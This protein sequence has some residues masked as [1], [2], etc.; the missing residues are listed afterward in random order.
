[1][2]TRR[3][4]LDPV[5]GIAGDMFVGAMLDAWPDHAEGTVGAI[6]AAGLADWVTLDVRPH[7][8]HALT[9]TRFDVS[10]PK[11]NEHA[12]HTPFKLVRDRLRASDLAAGPRDRAIDIFT[13]LADAEGRVH[14][15]DR[16]DVTFHEVGNWDSV[17]DVVGAAYLIDAVGD[18]GW[19]VGSLPMGSGR[20]KSAHGMLALPAPAVTELLTGFVMH[21]DGREGER[22]TPTGA[23]ILSH[24]EPKQ[25]GPYPPARLMR[26]GTGFGTREFPGIS[27]VLRVLEFEAVGLAV[28][29]DEV[30]VVRFEIDDQTP[31]DLAVGL[32]RLRAMAGVLDVLQTPAY[33]KK[34]RLVAQIQVLARPDVLDDVLAGC[35]TEST[36]L[37]LRWEIVRRATLERST[38][39]HDTVGVK[40]ARRPA[41]TV[42]AKAEADDLAGI[43]GGHDA[44]MRRRRAAEDAALE[45]SDDDG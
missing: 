11:A 32:D 21:D 14:G 25:G 12:H 45:D 40:L 4:H 18:A 3:L 42:T 17:A 23:A 35:F 41:G 20:V 27:N 26:N 19:S 43:E 44:R 38:R 33:G 28:P 13:R 15:V 30:A 34:G 5:G 36:T 31:E 22:V 1:M 37:G 8:D 9:G 2:T 10:A 39:R 7:K 16:E 29:A 24:L 6:R